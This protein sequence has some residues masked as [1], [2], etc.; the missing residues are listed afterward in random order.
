LA[1]PPRRAANPRDFDATV[2]TVGHIHQTCG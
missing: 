1:L 2:R